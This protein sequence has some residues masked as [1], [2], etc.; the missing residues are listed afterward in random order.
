ML[1]YNPKMKLKIKEKKIE[2]SGNG[3]P[4]LGL[5][6]PSETPVKQINIIAINNCIQIF[7]SHFKPDLFFP[8]GSKLLNLS[9]NY[10]SPQPLTKNKPKK[11]KIEKIRE[12]TVNDLITAQQTKASTTNSISCLHKHKHTYNHTYTYTCRKKNKK[13]KNHQWE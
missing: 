7:K 12:K 11:K 2:I 4:S 13:K 10:P 3:L 6:T 1:K 9:I 8:I 5:V